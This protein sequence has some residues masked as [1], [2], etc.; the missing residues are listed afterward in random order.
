MTVCL[1]PNGS[2]VFE[3]QTAPDEVLVA[4]IDGVARLRSTGP[5][6]TWRSEDIQLP[7]LHISSILFEPVGGGLFAGVHGEGL[8][9]SADG[10]RSWEPRMS[11]LT[12]K[13]VFSLASAQRA[14]SVV[15]YAGTEPAHLFQSTDYGETWTE[16]PTLRQVPELDKWTF[17]A[18]PHAGHVKAFAF[19][20][21]DDRTF[22]VCVEQGALLKTA[23]GG[24]TW[25]ELAGYAKREDRAYKDVHR[26]VLRPDQP[27]DLF[28]TNGN[29]F[30]LSHDG[31]E[32]WEHVT[33]RT[34]RIGY[35]DQL[36]VSPLDSQVLFMAG[37]E[38]SPGA[39][40]T[41]HHANA[42]VMRSSDGARTWEPAGNGLPENMRANLEAMS[43]CSY[44][45]GFSLFAATTDGEVFASD[46]QARTWRRIASG[47]PPVSK[48]GHYVALQ[49]AAA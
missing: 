40:R 21:R 27:D 49:E 18:P 48:V 28:M 11:G 38:V 17:P 25:R 41:T 33:D 31:G 13:H 3:A 8:Y 23:D 24:Q 43:L 16:L 46:D 37:S 47:L 19:D 44:P 2:N 12:V 5:G 7:G 20:P 42:T 1:S 4:T 26:L 35:P 10:G 22:Y 30:Y 6:A 9:Y 39:W 32:T 45:G 36:V 15:L 14:G 34:F 29:G